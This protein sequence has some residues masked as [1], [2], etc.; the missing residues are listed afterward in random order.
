MR[1]GAT[2]SSPP[3]GERRGGRELTFL[4]E[5]RAKD[6]TVRVTFMKN[7]FT[8]ML[9]TLVALA[10]FTAGGALLL[11]GGLAALAAL[12]SRDKTAPTFE[13]GSY[14]VFNLST[15]ITDA[16]PPISFASLGGGDDGLQLRTVT[17][18]LQ[19]A[20]KDD[21]IA[22]VYLTGDLAPAA[23]GAGYA[24]LREVRQALADFRSA[25]KPIVAYL[26]HATTKTYYLASTASE[27]VVD[28]YGMIIMPG[29]ASEPTFF[30]GA[31]A[32]YGI[33]VQVTRVGKYKSAVE[34]F[35]RKEMSPENREEL[36]ELLN[37]IWGGLLGDM[38][39]SRE[40][41]PAQI[42]HTVDAEGLIRALPA[43][44]ARLVDRIA[45]RDEVYDAL[46]AKTGRAGSKEPFKQIAL[47]D[48]AKQIRDIAAGPVLAEAGRKA[49]RGGRI[50]VVY[51]EGEIVDGEGE[52]GEIGGAALSR[53]LRK[54]RQDSTVKAVV[55]R[56]NSPGGSASASEVIQREVRL[57][58]AV[59]PLVVSMGSYAASGG[60]WISAPADRIF[61]EPTTITGS[62]GVFGLQF[63]IQKL[64][65]DFGVTFDSVKTGKFADT[66]TLS[67]PK[68]T[69]ELAVLQRMVDWI[70]GEFV[71]KVAEGRGLTPEKVEQIAQGRVW[72]G[73]DALDNGLV[74]ELGGLDAA[75]AYAAEKAGLAGNYRLLE[76]P[77]QKEFI[78]AVQE[79]IEHRL[80]GAAKASRGV[81]AG[82]LG[83]VEAELKVLRS[84]ND[85]Q[86]IYARLPLT[87][88][89]R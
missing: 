54:L 65:G 7:F 52:M 9:G 25:G 69:E 75:I 20:A 81:L 22:G 71:A 29:L 1:D 35:T 26:T 31:F 11:V 44:E 3:P 14:L 32:K 78:E 17:R 86:G 12:G 85:P 76:L 40:L 57:I 60:Y 73:S 59:K 64:A 37:D 43:R 61:A 42:Q 46:K 41:T 49:S 68:T 58:K 39:V 28:P 38:A 23:F 34:P 15:N 53:A 80:P 83:Q 87:V 5:E 63:D 82:L 4:L 13:R 16:P 30:A 2:C 74:D 56:V 27:L 55:L 48:Y 72:S 47:T 70:Y 79:M 62:I 24:A 66:L 89:I 21:R 36:Q 88:S 18:A 8:S 10:I 84:F 77:R 51:A 33:N 45:Y 50:A 67:R 6:G 19:A